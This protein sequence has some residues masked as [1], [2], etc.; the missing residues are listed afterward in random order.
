MRKILLLIWVWSLFSG[1]VLLWADNGI[2]FPKVMVVGAAGKIN[3]LSPNHE[4]FRKLESSLLDALQKQD[5]PV[6][7]VSRDL[8]HK[9]RTPASLVQIALEQDVS[10]ILLIRLII[11]K[12]VG[13]P[14]HLWV[15]LEGEL[16][17]LSK[18]GRV[19]HPF[20]FSSSLESLR[21]SCTQDCIYDVAGRLA[22]TLVQGAVEELSARLHFLSP[23]ETDDEKKIIYQLIFYGFKH[24]SAVNDILNSFE[25]LPGYKRHWKKRGQRAQSEQTYFYETSETVDNLVS[26]FL[27]AIAELDMSSEIQRLSPTVLKII[28]EP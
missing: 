27:I 26:R 10:Y 16:L 11:D 21:V 22:Q 7:R 23:L 15:E 17:N 25:A 3:A 12:D 8:H 24:A 19:D 18:K 4:V 20:K 14:V 1:P 28:K 13:D 6:A 9:Q 2:R 5:I